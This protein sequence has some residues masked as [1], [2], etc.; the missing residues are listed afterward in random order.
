MNTLQYE[1]LKEINRHIFPQHHFKPTISYHCQMNVNEAVIIIN[2]ELL[3]I[4]M[5]LFIK[6]D[7]VLKTLIYISIGEVQ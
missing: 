2:V 7:W 4:F 3:Q 1:N 6:P 5:L